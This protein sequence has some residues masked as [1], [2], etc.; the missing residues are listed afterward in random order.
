MDLRQF[1][2]GRV[3]RQTTMSKPHTARDNAQPAGF[4][5]PTAWVHPEPPEDGAAN[6][7]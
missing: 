5:L 6:A 4:N 3:A 1:C 7:R 2:P